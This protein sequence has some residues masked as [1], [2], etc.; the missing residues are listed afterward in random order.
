MMNLSS[1]DLAYL[2]RHN[3]DPSELKPFTD[4]A[5]KGQESV[6]ADQ[7]KKR[8]LTSLNQVGS[9]SDKMRQSALN[10]ASG[11]IAGMNRSQTTGFG[12]KSPGLKGWQV[13]R[14]E[15]FFQWSN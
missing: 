1:G 5:E 2:K 12:F 8:G 7:L 14:P 10:M 9:Q 6:V 13:D 15:S 3:V 4:E 11:R